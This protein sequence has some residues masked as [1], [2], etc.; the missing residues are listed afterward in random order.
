ML[1]RVANSIYWMN[2]YIERAENIARFIDVNLNLLL[3]APNETNQQWAPLI[4]TTGDRSLF[5]Q[6]YGEATEENVIRFLTFD[7]SYPNSILSCLISAR[8][9]ARSIREII[10]SEMWQQINAFY[11]LVQD[12]ANSTDPVDWFS[13]FEQVK[14]ASHLYLG[15]ATATM[16]HNEGWHF[17]Q[18]GRVLERADKTTRI[19]DVKYFILLPSVRDVGSSLDELQWV[20]LLRSTSGYEMYR[21]CGMH[22]ITPNAIAAFLLLDREFPRSIR[23]CIRQAER[24]LHQI[25]GTSIDTWDTPVE[26]VL[27]RLR[28]DLDYYTIDELVEDGLHEFLDSLQSRMNQVDTRIFETFFALEPV[29]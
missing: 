20:S 18:L 28:A 15:I 6:R 27:G 3:D 26:R 21:K 29:S 12:T 10:S 2:R 22:R 23:F 19:L 11:H 9:N 5:E 24:S 7:K 8:E 17:G 13:F 16:T 4:L 1:S 25:T 14:S